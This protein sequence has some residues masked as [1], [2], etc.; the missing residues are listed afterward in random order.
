M[1]AGLIDQWKNRGWRPDQL[2]LSQAQAFANG[3]G[4][5]PHRLYRDRMRILNACDFGDLCCTT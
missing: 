5:A 2:P 1:L 4:Q 3:K